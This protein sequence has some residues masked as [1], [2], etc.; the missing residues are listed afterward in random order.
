MATESLMMTLA[1]TLSRGHVHSAK[2]QALSLQTVLAGNTV[3]MQTLGS[4][5]IEKILHLND[6]V[7]ECAAIANQLAKLGS[8]SLLAYV[9]STSAT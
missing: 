4:E 6:N 1:S 7:G 3:V 9:Q 8:V 5:A 2:Q